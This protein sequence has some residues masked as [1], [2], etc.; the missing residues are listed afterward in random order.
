MIDPPVSF[1]IP[2]APIGAVRMTKS[3][4]WKQ[5][6]SVM[7]YRLWCDTARIAA[8]DVILPKMPDKIY[9]LAFLPIPASAS[10]KKSGQPHR[11]K[12]DA[13]NILKALCDALYKDQDSTIWDKH[14]VK[15]W[16]DGNGPRVEVFI[17]GK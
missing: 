4:K 2:G 14:I 15:R 1:I 5:R 3:D 10:V 7:R 16:D 9:A 6:P 13:D 11:S 17:W 12:P 8:R